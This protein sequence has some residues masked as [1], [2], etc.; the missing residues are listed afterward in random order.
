M[1][2][3]RTKNISL[4]TTTVSADFRDISNLMNSNKKKIVFV[5]DG[6]QK[7]I[8]TISDGD[9]RRAKSN[10][11]N[12]NIEEIINHQFTWKRVTHKE[13]DIINSFNEKIQIIPLLDNENRIKEVAYLVDK[14][15]IHIG[16]RQIGE[17]SSTFIIAEIGNNHN[18]DINLAKQLVD[19][20]K[21]AEAD[22]VKFQLR[23]MDSLYNRDQEGQHDLGVEYVLDLLDKNQL[24]WDEMVEIFDYSKSKGIMPLCTPWDIESVDKLIS[25]GM[26]TIKVASAD[27][28]NPELLEYAISKGLTLICSTGMSTEEEIVLANGLIN[29]LQGNVVFLHCNSTYPAP[30]KDINLNYLTKLKKL[31]NRLVGYSGHERGFHIPLA[32]VTLGACVIEKHF[33]LDRGMEGNDHKVSLLPKEFSEMVKQIRELELSFGNLDEQRSLTQGELINR[34][35]LSKSIVAAQSISEGAVICREML[36]YKSPGG[37]LQ[38]I[39]ANKLIGKKAKKDFKVG[40]VFYKSDILNKA[41]TNCN[42]SF[43]RPYGIPVRFHDFMRLSKMANLDFVEFHLTYNDLLKADKLFSPEK[44][45]DLGFAL[46][47]PEL[48]ENDFLLDLA[49]DDKKIAQLSIDKLKKVCDLATEMSEYFKNLEPVKIITNVGGFSENGFMPEDE[50]KKRYEILAS[51]LEHF[52]DKNTEVIIQSMPPYPWHFGGQSYHNLFVDP[53]ETKK[54][55]EDTKRRICLDISHSSMSSKF[56]N[57]DLNDFI[58]IVGDHTCYMHIADSYGLDGEGVD[59]GNGDVDFKALRESLDNY[60]SRDAWFIPEIWQGHKDNGWGFWNALHFLQ[61]NSF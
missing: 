57:I 45:F 39:E 10:L 20:A 44:T 30:F 53:F 46:H 28:T 37:G 15:V 4:F 47:A 27:L 6:Q 40:D 42:F 35:N 55:C 3:Y 56:L 19:L 38:P 54:F 18:G 41:F 48:F 16:N 24:S 25:Y 49:S 7:L 9:L 5:L 23:N 43:S 34:E 2:L 14:R 60:V 29:N 50:K 22:C 32:A 1:I 31:T 36:S 13:S 59:V 51:S 21:E 61:E 11:A 17:G 8:G 52:N 58:S 33:T 26:D 12:F